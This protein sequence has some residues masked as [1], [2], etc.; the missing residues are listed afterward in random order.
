MEK[1]RKDA[2]KKIKKFLKKTSEVNKIEQ[3][4]LDYA[5]KLAFDEDCLIL[6]YNNKLDDIIM[7]LD[8]KSELKN[9][10]LLEAIKNKE[11]DLKQIAFLAPH[12]LFPNRW[13]KIIDRRN[14]IEYK[15][16]NPTTTDIYTCYKCG[17]K[18]CTVY[19]M[20]TRSAD[21]PMTTFVTCLVCENKWNF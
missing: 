11:I 20:Q 14:L 9:D 8:P 4:I 18:K 1:S 7:N 6:T 17:K 16:T 21:E 2:K 12:K 5:N 3:S 15:K 19:Q 13:K 10:Y